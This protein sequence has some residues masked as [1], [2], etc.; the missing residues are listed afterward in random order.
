LIDH[1][2]LRFSFRDQMVF[3]HPTNAEPPICM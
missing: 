3:F 1:D 2:T